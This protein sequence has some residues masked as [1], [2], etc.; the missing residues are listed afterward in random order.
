MDVYEGSTKFEAKNH[1]SSHS[2]IVQI[3]LSRPGSPEKFSGKTRSGMKFRDMNPSATRSKYN[4]SI[5]TSL[6][7]ENTTKSK[8]FTSTSVQVME[9]LLQAFRPEVSTSAGTL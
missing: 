5:G 9:K 7:E 2:S 8:Q 6:E 4:R 1:A 3:H